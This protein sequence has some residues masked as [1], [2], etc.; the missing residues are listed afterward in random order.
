LKPH[1]R[2]VRFTAVV[3]PYLRLP[4]LLLG[5]LALTGCGSIGTCGNPDAEY[6]TARSNESLR[7]PQGMTQPDRSAALSVPAAVAPKPAA[8]EGDGCLEMPPDYLGSSGRSAR[9]VEEVVAS[10]AQSWAGRDAEAVLALYSE[11]FDA[12]T[13]SGRGPWLSERREQI[14]TGPLPDSKVTDMQVRTEDENRR[15]VTFVH[16][17]GTNALRKELTLVREGTSWRIVNE[18]V[19]DVQ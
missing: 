18:R 5:A 1:L 19:L 9:T 8:R 4:A 16:R 10:W 6:L 15:V 12:P 17:F 13:G 11:S 7:V 2:S 3:V 14:A